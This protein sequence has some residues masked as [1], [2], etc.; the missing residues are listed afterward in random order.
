MRRSLYALFV[1]GLL[2]GCAP[3]HPNPARDRFGVS[4]ARA[5]MGTAPVAAPQLAAL[6]RRADAICTLGFEAAP[7]TILPAEDRQQ[8]VEQKLR[9]RH[10]DRIMFHF[11]HADWSNI[12]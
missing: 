6:A 8:L 9:C 10:Y 4:T 3:F 11:V 7:P 1:L 12:L 2:A 5:D